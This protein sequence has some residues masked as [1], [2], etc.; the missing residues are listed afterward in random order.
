MLPV[1]GVVKVRGLNSDVRV[2]RVL[3]EQ[4]NTTSE[5]GNAKVIREALVLEVLDRL[6]ERNHVPFLRNALCNGTFSATS[7][8]R[9]PAQDAEARL[10][11]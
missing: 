10:L 4:D 11:E 7:R 5:M 6:L 9:I 8:S 2:K 1:S 3:V